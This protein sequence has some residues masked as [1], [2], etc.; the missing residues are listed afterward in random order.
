MA[1]EKMLHTSFL[2]LQ[3]MLFWGMEGRK[4][5]SFLC[6]HSVFKIFIA[7]VY[8]L[9]KCICQKLTVFFFQPAPPTE[10][11]WAAFFI[12][13][14]GMKLLGPFPLQPVTSG[15]NKSSACPTYSTVL[16][17]VRLFHSAIS[18]GW[19]VVF[20]WSF[21]L[22]FLDDCDLFMYLSV[23]LNFYNSVLNRDLFFLSR[24]SVRVIIS[25]SSANCSSVPET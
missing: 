19:V 12:G 10:L 25:L 18:G 9:E 1:K 8:T 2:C 21:N 11:P 15:V 20:C 4:E 16:A 3:N 23:I 13:K 22:H 24:I 7:L 6:C 14:V 5:I 17:I